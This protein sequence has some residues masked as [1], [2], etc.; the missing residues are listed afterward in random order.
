MCRFQINVWYITWN[1]AVTNR[2]T[3]LNTHCIY[4]LAFI[5]LAMLERFFFLSLGVL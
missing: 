2:G 5:R 4:Q 3:G 1:A